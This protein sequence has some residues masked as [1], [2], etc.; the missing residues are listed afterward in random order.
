MRKVVCVNNIDGNQIL[1]LTIGKVYDEVVIKTD[2][3]IGS[4]YTILVKNDK[5]DMVDYLSDRFRDL[6]EVRSERID[7]LLK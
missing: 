5:G 7:K 6:A 2:V 3:Y 1:N 4:G